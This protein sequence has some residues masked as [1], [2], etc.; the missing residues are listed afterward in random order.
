MSHYQT[1]STVS[2][3]P[4]ESGQIGRRG[5]SSWHCWVDAMDGRH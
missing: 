5:G 1:D 3:S 4:A 2:W